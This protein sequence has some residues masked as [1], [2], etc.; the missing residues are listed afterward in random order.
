M[1]YQ[2]EYIMKHQFKSTDLTL[3]LELE[4]QLINPHTQD[5]TSRSKKL[6]RHINHSSFKDNIK[7]EIT[8]SMIEVNSSVHYKPTSLHK[9][10]TML[11]HYLKHISDKEN[12]SL[13]GGGTHPF[14]DWKKRKIFP[15][16]RF[17]ALSKKYGYLA[18]NYTVFSMHVHVGCDSP[19]KAI[20]LTHALSRFVP[21]LICLS[22][23][24]PFSNGTQTGFES[25]RLNISSSF[26]LSG[27]IPAVKNWSEFCRYYYKMQELNIIESMKD[28][29][30]D[31]RPKPEL[32]TVEI[33]VCDM[34]LTLFKATVLTAYI[35]TISSYIMNEFPFD[36]QNNL[37]DLY[38]Y[39]RFQAS[40]FGFDGVFINPYSLDKTSI[41]KDIMDTLKILRPYAKALGTC[42]YLREIKGLTKHKENDSALL[43]NTFATSESLLMTVREKCK[44]WKSS[45]VN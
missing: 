4:L 22:A 19:D 21:Q 33:R 13:C 32:G 31:I 38:A 44:A 12:V 14:Q 42:H 36:F 16:R 5:L 26:P 23:S 20:Y 15:T 6:I 25:T 41:Q 43:K 35:Q 3:G 1:L 40:R 39:N 28:F 18:K 30:W 17:H 27:H 45:I 24:S 2:G 29:Y 8:Q 9:E 11:C 7:P 34:P 37:Y 10:M